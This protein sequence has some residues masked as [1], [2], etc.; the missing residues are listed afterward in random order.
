MAVSWLVN[1]VVFLSDGSEIGK[2]YPFNAKQ[3]SHNQ[4]LHAPGGNSESP[5]KADNRAEGGENWGDIFGGAQIY[6]QRR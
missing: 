3:N 1:K 6:E 4:Q 2:I 5:N